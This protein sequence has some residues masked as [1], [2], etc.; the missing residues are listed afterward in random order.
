MAGLMGG[1]MNNVLSSF[2]SK[3]VSGL[4]R[5]SINP[6]NSIEMLGSLNQVRHNRRVYRQDRNPW[7]GQLRFDKKPLQEW[8]E[9]DGLGPYK[10]RHHNYA[11]NRVLKDVQRRRIFK[12]DHYERSKL[13]DVFYNDVLPKEVRDKAMNK[14]INMPF[15]SSVIRLVDRCVV[16]GRP[17][18]VYKEFRAS[19]F[20]FRHEADHNRVSGAQR[21]FWLYNTHIKP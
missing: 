13:Q 1:L 6:L 20:I 3:S 4:T 15:D 17:R 5:L 14:I 10:Y 21:A 7:K 8:W 16:T 2:C 18:G 11:D 12:R 19:R 9:W